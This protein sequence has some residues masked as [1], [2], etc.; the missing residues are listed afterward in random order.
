VRGADGALR[1]VRKPADGY[2]ADEW[3]KR[4]GDGRDVVNAIAARKDGVSCDGYGCIAKGRDGTTIVVVSRVDALAEDC[5]NAA[6]V[7]SAVPVGRD[8]TQPKLV[9]D[10]FDISR[11]GGYA[12]WLG[13][14]THVE[15]VEGGRGVRPW[16]QTARKRSQYRRM[17]PTSLP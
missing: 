8:C 1:L 15:T 4:D 17:R 5:A 6:I 13:D 14:T 12:V 16:S 10:K 7:V 2:S 3:L 11:A 9:I